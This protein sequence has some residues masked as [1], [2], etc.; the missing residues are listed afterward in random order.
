MLFFVI[1]LFIFIRLKKLCE[2][3]CDYLEA[4]KLLKDKCIKSYFCKG[5]VVEMLEKQKNGKISSD[6]QQK[7]QSKVTKT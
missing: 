4:L 1:F 6:H 5:L 2:Q 3:D 7:E